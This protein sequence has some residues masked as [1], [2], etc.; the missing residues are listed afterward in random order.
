MQ[1]QQ[2]AT[3]AHKR[4]LSYF[5]HILPSRT[6]SEDSN[7]LLLLYFSVCG[8]VLLKHEFSDAERQELIQFVYLH[9]VNG[10]FRGSLSHCVFPVPGVVSGRESGGEKLEEEGIKGS[11]YDP[12]TLA[13]TY[14][15]LCILKTLGDDLA[16][17]DKATVIKYI[18]AC[19]QPNGAF[20]SYVAADGE[21][22]NDGDLRQCYLAC[23]ISKLLEVDVD[24]D[25]ESAAFDVAG[26]EKYVLAQ[27]QYDGGLGIGESHAGL[28][29]CGLGALK[30]IGSKTLEDHNT[31]GKT[32]EWLVHR[33]ISYGEYNAEQLEYEF[34]DASDE[35]AFNGRENKYGDTCYAYWVLG[36]LSI[37]QQRKNPGVGETTPLTLI[38]VDAARGYLLNVTQN[39]TRGGFAKSDIDDPD[40]FHTYLG[41][42][43]LSLLRKGDLDLDLDLA[44]LD[45]VL[46]VPV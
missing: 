3:A 8:L 32:L 21:V 6:Q 10:G 11:V 37:L 19:Q 5:L 39:Q 26:M 12:P 44:E 25:V 14:A 23:C 4:Y 42:C 24:V 28:T 18:C 33:Q 34:C 41:L 35:G 27:V 38:D 30:L 1:Q 16:G 20:S 2:L 43:A 31:C 29:F 36:S 9:A 15:A 22:L 7:K 46:V 45:P 40:P 17:V 13:A